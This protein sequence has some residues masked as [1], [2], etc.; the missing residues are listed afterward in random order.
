ME[1]EGYEP[2]IWGWGWPADG[3]FEHWY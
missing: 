1:V 3:S 2:D